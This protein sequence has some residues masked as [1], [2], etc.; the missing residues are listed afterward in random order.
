[1]KKSTGLFVWGIGLGASLLW[2]WRWY[3]GLRRV[4]G[5]HLT[6]ADLSYSNRS[7]DELA[8]EHLIDL[9]TAG[10]NQLS[11][12][13]IS[14]ESLERLLENRPYRNK[15]ELVSRMVLKEDEYG[16]IKDRVAVS[17]A[18]EPVKTTA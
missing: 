13:G 4:R 9:N 6:T 11:E 18:S 3:Q 16:R 12:L 17:A 2:G 10:A 7:T 5:F 14:A 1:M 15:L 8:S